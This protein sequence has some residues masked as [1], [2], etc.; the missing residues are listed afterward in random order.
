MDTQHDGRAALRPPKAF[1]NLYEGRLASAVG[2]EDSEDLAGTDLE[3]RAGESLE[4]SIGF[5]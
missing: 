4:V 1:K 3:G 5:S 2:A